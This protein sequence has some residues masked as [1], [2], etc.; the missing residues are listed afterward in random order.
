MNAQDNWHMML[1]DGYQAPSASARR[2]NQS[3]EEVGGSPARFEDTERLHVRFPDEFVETKEGVT[4]VTGRFSRSIRPFRLAEFSWGQNDQ[5]S[6]GETRLTRP[7]EAQ[8]SVH[9]LPVLIGQTGNEPQGIGRPVVRQQAHALAP[10]KRIRGSSRA[11]VDSPNGPAKPSR[12]T[13]L[14]LKCRTR[15]PER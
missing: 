11:D 14:L 3:V 12:W 4:R 10:D 13:R 1:T 15:I 2:R 6:L 7:W 8:C 9:C 5:N